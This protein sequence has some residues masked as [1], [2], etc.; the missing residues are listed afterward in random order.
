MIYE[1]Q[2]FSTNINDV[3]IM[4]TGE[5]DLFGF[6]LQGC[7]IASN[8]PSDNATDTLTVN[9][10]KNNNILETKVFERYHS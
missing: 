4:N 5:N 3:R 8:D 6:I 10:I 7:I 2:I 1:E 9:V